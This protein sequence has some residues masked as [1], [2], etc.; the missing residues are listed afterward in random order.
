MRKF[1]K[2]HFTF[3]SEKTRQS[4][5][6]KIDEFKGCV[7]DIISVSKIKGNTSPVT[8]DNIVNNIP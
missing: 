3:G 4:S 7:K 2:D 5:S 1:F 6:R 8:S